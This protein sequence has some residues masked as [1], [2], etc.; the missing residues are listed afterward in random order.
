MAIYPTKT[1]KLNIKNKRNRIGVTLISVFSIFLIL[2]LF[3]FFRVFNIAI[4][5]T[6]GLLFYPFSIFMIVVGIM[7]LCG[8]KIRTTK[9]IMILSIVWLVIFTMIIHLATSKNIDAG[10]GDY[11]STTFKSCSTAGGVIFSLLVYPMNNLI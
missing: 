10:F 2:L 3:S 8:K 6:F 5:G 4:L 1:N 9:T 11:I 7:T